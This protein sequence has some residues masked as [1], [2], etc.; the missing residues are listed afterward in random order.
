MSHRLGAIEYH[1]EVDGCQTVVK[2]ER[3][4]SLLSRAQVLDIFNAL[5]QQ[6][7][8]QT[9]SPLR[10]TGVRPTRRGTTQA[11]TGS[12]CIQ[13]AGDALIGQAHGRHGWVSSAV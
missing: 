2:F 6:T 8:L 11:T 7:G 1:Q 4:G 5:V 12:Q 10:L 3:T 9:C 13:P